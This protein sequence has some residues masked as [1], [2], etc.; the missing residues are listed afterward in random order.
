ME[1]F[2]EYFLNDIRGYKILESLGYDPTRSDYREVF[3]VQKKR[4][5]FI[6]KIERLDHIAEEKN[7]QFDEEIRIHSHLSYLNIAPKIIDTWEAYVPKND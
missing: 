1:I 5:K 4:T 2:D 6:L 3:I 7:K